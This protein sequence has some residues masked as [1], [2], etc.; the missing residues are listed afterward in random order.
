MQQLQFP[1][2]PSHKAIILG[3]AALFAVLALGLL[4]CA[5]EMA[6]IQDPIRYPFDSAKWKEQASRERWRM[7]DDLMQKHDLKGKTRNELL[8]LLGPPDDADQKD[9]ADQYDIGG[10]AGFGPSWVYLRIW[11]LGDKVANY[12]IEEL[13]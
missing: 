6:W 7:H 8:K 11:Y 4:W 12:K 10:A 1:E 2:A 5:I 9:N 3:I 13:N